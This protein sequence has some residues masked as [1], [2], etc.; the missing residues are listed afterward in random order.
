MM[1]FVAIAFAVMFFGTAVV[2][3]INYSRVLEL[4]HRL[5]EIRDCDHSLLTCQR[6]QGTVAAELDKVRSR[7]DSIDKALRGEP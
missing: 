5:A 2:A 3:R 7:L 4:E 6:W 1:R